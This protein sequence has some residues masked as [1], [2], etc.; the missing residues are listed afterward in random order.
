MANLNGLSF[1]LRIGPRGNFIKTTGINKIKDNIKNIVYTKLG[2]RHMSPTFGTLG[3][4]SLLRNTSVN[5]LNFLKN[6]II[7][8]IEASDNRIIVVSL[9]ITEPREDGKMELFLQFRL[10][11]YTEYQDLVVLF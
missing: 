3:H 9:D 2:E 4:L 6:N 8:G 7:R 5:D 11:N 1:P 10:D